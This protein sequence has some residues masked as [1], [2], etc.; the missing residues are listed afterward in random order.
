MNISSQP[1]ASLVHYML[2]IRDSAKNVF[3]MLLHCVALAHRALADVEAMEKLFTSPPGR[4]SLQLKI[5]SQQERTW[6]LA[7]SEGARAEGN[8]TYQ[9]AW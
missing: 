2:C 7:I 1:K 6:S 9:P 3:I 5:P 8:K 4:M